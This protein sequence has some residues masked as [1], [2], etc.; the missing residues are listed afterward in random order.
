[1]PD[2]RT[3]LG[4]VA[5]TL[6][7]AGL[8]LA[9]DAAGTGGAKVA[10]RPNGVTVSWQPGSGDVAVEQPDTGSAGSTRTHGAAAVHSSRF[11]FTLRVAALLADIGYLSEHLG[12]RVL[13]SGHDVR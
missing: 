7:E 12:D 8:P 2:Y 6:R 4:T 1:M 10:C 9:D 11:Q 3:L 5:A 13:I